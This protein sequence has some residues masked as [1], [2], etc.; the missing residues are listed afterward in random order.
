MSPHRYVT[1]TEARRSWERLIREVAESNT[2]VILTR[3]GEPIAVI[4]PYGNRS[5]TPDGPLD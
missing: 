3:Y 4:S 1:M 5:R 2:S